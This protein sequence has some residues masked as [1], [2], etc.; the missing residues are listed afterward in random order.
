VWEAAMHAARHELS[1]LI[2]I[3]DYNKLQSARPSRAALPS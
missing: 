2:V 3:V 1:N